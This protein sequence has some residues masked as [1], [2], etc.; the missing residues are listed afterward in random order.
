MFLSGAALASVTAWRIAAGKSY[1]TD[2]AMA[3]S[4]KDDP[5]SFWLSLLFPAL[6]AIGLMVIGTIGLW[7]AFNSN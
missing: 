6:F 2:P 1:V 5:F 7:R 4:R 3:V